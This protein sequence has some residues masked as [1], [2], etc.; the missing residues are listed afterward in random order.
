MR[1]VDD[2]VVVTIVCD[3]ES[4]I[5]STALNPAGGAPY[6]TAGGRKRDVNEKEDE[7]RSGNHRRNIIMNIRQRHW[8][9]L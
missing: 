2:T 4:M 6:D 3:P 9:L 7:D 1:L 8:L 5:L